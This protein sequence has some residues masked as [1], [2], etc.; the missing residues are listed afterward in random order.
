MLS[1][2]L[3]EALKAKGWTVQRLADETGVSKR[4]LDTFMS[5]YRSLG[6]CAART[7]L[8]IAK[9]LDV[10]PLELINDTDNAH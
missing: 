1:I 6:G 3:K 5:G 7:L 8:A 9:A 4:T 10:D 2:T